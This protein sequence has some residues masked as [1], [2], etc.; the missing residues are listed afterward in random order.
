MLVVLAYNASDKDRAIRLAEWIAEL[1]TVKTHQCLVIHSKQTDPEGIL[2]ALQSAFRHVVV[3]VPPDDAQ[4]NIA[5]KNLLFKRALRQIQAS[6]AGP[7]LWLEPDALPMR[8]GWLDALQTSWIMR[9]R[10]KHFVGCMMQNG[11]GTYMHAC[12]MYDQACDGYASNLVFAQKNP[13]D[14]NGGPQTVRFLA[15]TP[16]INCSP[17]LPATEAVALWHPV[18]EGSDEKVDA[19][20][21]NLREQHRKTPLPTLPHT[22]PDAFL[23]KPP[24]VKERFKVPQKMDGP[25]RSLERAMAGAG[26]EHLQGEPDTIMEPVKAAKPPVIPV[27]RPAIQE[28]DIVVTTE[29]V[30]ELIEQAENED[31][32]KA[33]V[34]RESQGEPRDSSP[35]VAPQLPVSEGQ[36]SSGPA[37]PVADPRSATFPHNMGET[38][39]GR[40]LHY[41]PSVL[42]HFPVHILQALL[43]YEAEKGSVKVTKTE[44]SRMNKAKCV[45]A[46]TA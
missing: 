45:E 26:S 29:A 39:R 36:A 9:P 31:L 38:K 20:L 11:W 44:I 12:G 19:M 22:D 18:G 2:P 46:L 28:R 3:M 15:V 24:E 8:P 13:F 23:H 7:F 37:Q 34:S 40:A 41:T 17:N 32:Q 27:P 4:G 1:G 6:N 33:L 42:A 10:G 14:A 35:S 5:G 16:L 30:R 25:D 21:N 43:R